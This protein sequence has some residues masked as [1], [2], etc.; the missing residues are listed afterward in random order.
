[1]LSYAVTEREMNKNLEAVDM[2]QQLKYWSAED[3]LYDYLIADSWY[4]VHRFNRFS[5][6]GIHITIHA[7]ANP[8]LHIRLDFKMFSNSSIL[9]LIAALCWCCLIIIRV[10]C[11][12][13]LD[14]AYASSACRQYVSRGRSLWRWTWDIGRSRWDQ[15]YSIRFLLRGWTDISCASTTSRKWSSCRYCCWWPGISSS[16]QRCW[17]IHC[18]ILWHSRRYN[19]PKSSSSR[20]PA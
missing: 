17:M 5:E 6:T 12:I 10:S 9:F 14:V 16:Y 8:S 18:R 13:P 4:G 1:M 15:G 3:Y 19:I 20:R 11:R 7:W 2:V